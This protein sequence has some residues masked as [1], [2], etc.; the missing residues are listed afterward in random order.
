LGFGFWVLGFG[1]WDLGF[2]FVF[3]VSNGGLEGLGVGVS[4]VQGVRSFRVEHSGV[5]V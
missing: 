3:W 4:K 2:G 5:K 1:I